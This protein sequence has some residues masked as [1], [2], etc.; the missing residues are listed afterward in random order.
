VLEMLEMLEGA[1]TR[2]ALDKRLLINK[3]RRDETGFCH[4]RFS[5][6]WSCL[7]LAC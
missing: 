3:T 1:K 6:A 7:V 4:S 2:Q 5:L